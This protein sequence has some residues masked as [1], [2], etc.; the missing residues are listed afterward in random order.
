MQTLLKT[1]AQNF[2]DAFLISAGLPFES[3]KALMDG[4][5]FTGVDDIAWRLVITDEDENCTIRPELILPMSVLKMQG[6]EILHMFGMQAYLFTE[7]R[8][9][10]NATD[11]GFLQLTSVVCSNDPNETVS[12]LDVARL[13]APQIMRYIVQGKVK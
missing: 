5:F 6:Q 2:C 8:W 12:M 10:L 7:M 13:I 11:K 1:E 9:W 3:R 4:S